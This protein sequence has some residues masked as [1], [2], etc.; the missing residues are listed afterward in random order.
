MTE[1]TL[2]L[3]N[4]YAEEHNLLRPRKF[5]RDGIQEGG[6]G[7][8]HNRCMLQQR[9]AMDIENSVA[10]KLPGRDRECNLGQN[11]GDPQCSL[12]FRA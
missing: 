10:K 4:E 7:I 8:G 5:C 1:E 2:S 3:Q 12:E 11:F 6:Q 9:P